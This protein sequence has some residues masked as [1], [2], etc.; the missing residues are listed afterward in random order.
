MERQKIKQYIEKYISELE[1]SLYEPIVERDVGQMP[2]DAAKAFFLLLP[3]LNGEQWTERLNTAAI[4]VGAVHAAFEAHDA[5]SVSDATSKQ[6]QLTVLSGD[7]F[8]GVHYRLLASIPELGFIQSLS[9]TIGHINEVKTTFHQRLPDE[10]V[11]LIEAVAVIEAGCITDYLHTFGFSKY[12]TLANAALPLLRLESGLVGGNTAN[13][14]HAIALLQD[15]LRNALQVADFLAPI[16]HQEIQNL[17]LP[18]L[19]KMI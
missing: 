7:H 6:Q 3:M 15:E 1:Q 4:A 14:D 12:A 17:A 11:Q 18:L 5:I 9:R 16:L 10:S 8:S 13:V 2:I 19:G